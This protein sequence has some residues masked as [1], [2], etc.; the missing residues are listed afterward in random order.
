[1]SERTETA[2]VTCFLRHQGEVLLLQRSD[3]VGSYAG[4]WGT[5][6]GH[7]EGDPDAAAR[8]EIQEETGRGE[9]VTLVRRGEPF[10]VDDA[11][12]GTRWVV[13]PYLFDCDR[14][15]VTLNWESTAAEWVM[16]AEI[17]RRETVPDLWTSYER[18]A[19]SV[20]SVAED[21]EHGS[22]Y[23]A[24]RAVEV[25]RDR[26]GWLRARAEVNPAIRLQEVARALLEARP[27]MAALGNR[28][29]RVMHATAPSFDPA[30]VEAEAHRVIKHAFSVGEAT[31]RYAA[32]HV[33]GQR[34]LT[35]S[36]SG[37]VLDALLHADPP[38]VVFVAESRPACEGVHVAERLARS[39]R[40]VTLCTDAAIS[41]VIARA[42]VDAVIVGADAVL[43][44]G[45]VVNKTGTRSAALAAQHA[46]IPVFVVAA[47]D[48][49]SPE[50][51]PHLEDDSPAA[52]YDG[53]AEVQVLNPTF[54]VTPAA[55]ITHWITEDGAVQREDVGRCA[56]RH[57]RWRM[58]A[59]SSRV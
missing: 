3:D 35:L 6:A 29:H 13:H 46:G 32:Q 38:P 42:A 23:I 2:V 58:W 17:L 48:K 56:A 41:A 28:I 39:G 25:L 54:D 10:P 44:S 53:E 19:P 52:L 59:T 14:Q 31:V 36:R 40:P 30:M 21:R 27:S 15:A 55:L 24:A 7:A 5:V 18:V 16:P 1:M 37:T 33:A 11:E 4:R 9:H 47:S 50:E 26:A 8:R 12:L 20:E 43:A 49:I 45:D 34:V 22:A 51:A 57:A